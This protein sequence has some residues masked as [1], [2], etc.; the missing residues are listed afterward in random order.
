M[1]QMKLPPE[2]PGRFKLF[3][4]EIT[5]MEPLTIVAQSSDEAYQHFVM[6]M[7]RAFGNFPDATYAV[8]SWRPKKDERHRTVLGFARAGRT[9]VAWPF[10]VEGGWELFAPW[11]D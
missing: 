7:A 6:G 9:G 11:E 8:T 3:K 2:N 10:S 1:T 5:A 4:V